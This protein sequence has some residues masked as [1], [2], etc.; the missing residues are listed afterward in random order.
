MGDKVPSLDKYFDGADLSPEVRSLGNNNYC[1]TKSQDN[2][3]EEK[4]DWC[5]KNHNR[6]CPHKCWTKEQ[7]SPAKTEWCC[8]NKK[9]G[10]PTYKC[11]SNDDKKW[12]R[13]QKRWCCEVWKRGCPKYKCWTNEKWSPEKKAWCCKN[14]SRGCSS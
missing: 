10:C 3:S 9:R 12:S 2:W 5:C 1:W 7:W 4:K 13:D 11:W 14:W 6:G 8:E